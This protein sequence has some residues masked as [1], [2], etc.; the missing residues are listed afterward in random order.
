MIATGWRTHCR[1]VLRETFEPVEY[2]VKFFSVTAS[3]YAKHRQLQWQYRRRDHRFAKRFLLYIQYQFYKPAFID[4]AKKLFPVIIH[5]LLA[6][7]LVT[8]LALAIIN[9][10]DFQFW[11]NI[12]ITVLL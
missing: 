9:K 4:K 11:F 7:L 3:S 12:A 2:G 6:G 1:R 5:S 10:N 8:S